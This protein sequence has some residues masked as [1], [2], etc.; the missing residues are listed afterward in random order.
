MVV[1]WSGGVVEWWSGGGG[2]V[3]RVGGTGVGDYYSSDTGTQLHLPLWLSLTDY[4]M[5]VR[6]FPGSKNFINNKNSAK[7][8][9]SVAIATKGQ[10]VGH[11][12]NK[13]L[14]GIL[15]NF[16]ISILTVKF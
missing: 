3:R 5:Y 4:H 14:D 16:I 15:E 6:I 7:R 10:R 1:W 2:G 9:I 11:V 8:H 13:G 12:S